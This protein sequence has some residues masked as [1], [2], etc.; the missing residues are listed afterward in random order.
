[1]VAVSPTVFHSNDSCKTERS[2][3]FSQI[4]VDFRVSTSVAI[5]SVAQTLVRP[6]GCITPC[7]PTTMLP[8]PILLMPWSHGD[9]ISLGKTRIYFDGVQSITLKSVDCAYAQSAET[10]L[11]ASQWDAFG[12]MACV[13]PKPHG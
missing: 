10:Q 13:D 1:M 8:V 5:L 12:R 6:V 9:F 7:T 2:T 3:T 4:Q 11:S